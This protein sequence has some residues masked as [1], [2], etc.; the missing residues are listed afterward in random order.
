MRT[1]D[2]IILGA[3]MYG[4]YAAGIS[5]GK[6]KSTL[7][8][9]MEVNP[10]CRGS[11]INQARLHN[12]YHYPRSYA[13]AKK[14]A[15]YF[16]RFFNDFR[17]CVYSDFTKIYAI[18][19]EYSWTNSSQFQRFC[20]KLN[21]RCEPIEKAKY[22]NMNV[23]EDAFITTEYSFDAELLRDKLLAKAK[24]RNCCFIMGRSIREITQGEGFFTITLSDGQ[25][26]KTKY[27]LNATYSGTNQIH[28]FLNYEM[29]PLKYELCEVILCKVSD[30]MKHVGITV[31]DGPFFSVMP[32]GVTGLHSITTVSRT[33]HFTSYASLPSFSCQQYEPECR[34]ESCQNCNHCPHRPDTT[35]T[36]MV[37]T[38]KKYLQVNIDIQY[39]KSL[40]TL[41]PILKASEIDDSR[42][43]LIKQYNESP[44]FYTVFSGKINTMYDLDD[45]L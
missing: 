34:P 8:V 31:M 10:F 33:P 43:T 23:I 26:Y 3:G 39:V 2:R 35:F 18:A 27:I 29:L 19:K 28:K 30:A 1:F 22:F 6:G 20:E 11:Y 41:K 32:F 9:D 38:A 4:L 7:V 13:T 5:S 15:H 25:S 42:P 12:G 45:I 44:D 24:N 16:D 40:F 14:S 36:E 17:E 21:L 37:Q